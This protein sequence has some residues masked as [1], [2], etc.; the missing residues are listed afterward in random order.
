MSTRGDRMGDRVSDALNSPP[1]DVTTGTL[2]ARKHRIW[3]A[4]CNALE[5]GGGDGLVNEKIYAAKVGTSQAALTAQQLATAASGT[6]VSSQTIASGASATLFNADAAI[7]GAVGLMIPGGTSIRFQASASVTA[8][9][10]NATIRILATLSENGVGTIAE[11]WIEGIHSETAEIYNGSFDLT[12]DY[13]PLVGD[14]GLTL[15]GYVDGAAAPIEINL[16]YNADDHPTWCEPALLL[17][18][19][20]SDADPLPDGVAASGAPNRKIVREGHVHPLGPPSATGGKLWTALVP[21]P[22]AHAPVVAI[23]GAQNDLLAVWTQISTGRWRR[24][25]SG[26]ISGSGWA[27]LATIAVGDRIFIGYQPSEANIGPD[28]LCGPYNVINTGY[29]SSG[30]AQY[31]EIVRSEDADTSALFVTGMWFEVLSGDKHAGEFWQ[32]ITEGPFVLGTTATEWEKVSEP[33]DASTNEL[34][35]AAEL[36]LA[37]GATV[38]ASQTVA[39]AETGITL[40][41]CVTHDVLAGQTIVAGEPWEFH[42]RSWLTADDP[43]A[44]TRI[45]V[46]IQN[47][48]GDWPLVAESIPMHHTTP[49]DFVVTG[50][51]VAGFDVPA[52]EKLHV[53]FV[54]WSASTTGVEVNLIYN[55]SDHPTWMQTPLVLGFS[56]TTVHNELTGRTAANCHPASSISPVGDTAT[57]TEWFTLSFTTARVNGIRVTLTSTFLFSGLSKKW[58]DGTT[59]PD[60]FEAL[61]YLRNPTPSEPATIAD[62]AS[63]PGGS[64]FLP[65]ALDAFQGASQ[66]KQVEGPTALWLWLDLIEQR[67]HLKSAVT[68]TVPGS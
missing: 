65:L 30:P 68:Y 17:D 57:G 23:C 51:L 46:Y 43:L 13:G 45:F 54:A 24:N 67:W 3:R 27:D 2:D 31:A 5:L 28:A 48:D 60:L 1:L 62:G 58:S 61:V 47:A 40:V 42:L 35:T 55:E 21:D 34:L 14:L 56:G 12:E 26:S 44:N 6:D 15:V 19:V 29:Y 20:L 8:D 50:A 10:P 11:A 33:A 66:S 37:S 25:V 32:L 53:R 38:T 41:E 9:D 59:I 16:T 39:N 7:T 36:Y 22:Y 63:P 64:D 49:M 52:G 18:M 4:I